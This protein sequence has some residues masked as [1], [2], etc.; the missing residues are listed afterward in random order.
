MAALNQAVSGI[1]VA[2]SNKSFASL[3][4]TFLIFILM[5]SILARLLARTIGQG[6]VTKSV[7]AIALTMSGIIV[8][9]LF[10]GATE[11]QFIQRVSQIAS[12]I[13]T[14]FGFVAGFFV[15]FLFRYSLFS[16]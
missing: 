10:F 14:L 11:T 9:S 12:T 8:L 4:F 5:Y 13:S 6:Q 7:K 1:L 15:F 16:S 2:I 3:V